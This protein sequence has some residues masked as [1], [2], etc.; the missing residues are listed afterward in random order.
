M[1]FRGESR[2]LTPLP[3]SENGEQL[4]QSDSSQSVINS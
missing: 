1:E 2:K 4:S 3:L